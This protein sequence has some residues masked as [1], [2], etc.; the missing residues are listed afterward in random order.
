MSQFYNHREPVYSP[1]QSVDM[2]ANSIDRAQQN[3]YNFFLRIIKYYKPEEVLNQFE[4]LFIRYEEID[5]TSAYHAL[6]EIIF[7]NKED[8]FIN[9]IL[10][11]FHILNNN[12]TINGNANACKKLID[13][14]LS[15]SIN[16][17][18]RTTKLRILRKWLQNFILSSEYKN[19]RSF[20]DRD[21]TSKNYQTWSDRFS[22]Y[23]LTSE[24]VDLNKSPEQRQYA[25]TL[26]RQL[27]KQ[28]KFD[29]AMYT[30]RLGA[31][32]DL[33]SKHQN[34]TKLGDDVLILIKRVLNKNGSKNF[35][36][37]AKNFYK[38]IYDLSFLGFKKRFIE[39]LSIPSND[40]NTSETMQLLVEKKL[41]YLQEK[42]NNQGMTLGLLNVTC[43]G[44]LQYILLNERRQP[45]KLLKSSLES[46]NFLNLVILLLKIVLLLPSSRLHLEKHI[47]D[48]IK[49]HSCYA[50]TECIAFINFLDVLNVTLAI[51]EED[52]DYSLIKMNNGE[53]D[54]SALNL[55]NYRIFS[56]SKIRTNLVDRPRDKLVDLLED[57]LANTVTLNDN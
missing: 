54:L 5:S 10:R 21:K 11:C 38:Q 18:T 24:Y 30:A 28:F 42:Q 13:L 2:T 46:N 23:L 22:S 43:C 56:Q 7:Y 35:K 45:S 55:E 27:K 41:K 25:E 20:S 1:K 31:S 34:P 15:T 14:F 4:K 8:E 44:I 26:S 17:P 57:S 12:W 3:I 19:L 49:F 48:L 40:L 6:G 51:F 33:N 32:S 47:A 36:I 50:E 53:N 39:Y 9:T 16:I 29:L 52:T 37:T